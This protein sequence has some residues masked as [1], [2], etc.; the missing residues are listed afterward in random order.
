MQYHGY[1]EAVLL[2][3][4]SC[5]IL[6]IDLV[7]PLQGYIGM[8]SFLAVSCPLLWLVNNQL[9]P[10][11]LLIQGKRCQVS[12]A[13]VMTSNCDSDLCFALIFPTG[14]I[15]ICCI[16]VWYLVFIRIIDCMLPAILGD[17]LP[18]PKEISSGLLSCILGGFRVGIREQI[19]NL[20]YVSEHLCLHC[21]V[22]VF[23]LLVYCVIVA[24]GG[25]CW[26]V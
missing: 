2:F 15:P 19:G 3:T 8:L 5:L 18:M 11:K 9:H 10:S 14:T 17:G 4:F 25:V 12:L 26:C 24:G 7:L 13:G 22:V 20:S 23:V 1:F 6:N 16:G 21:V